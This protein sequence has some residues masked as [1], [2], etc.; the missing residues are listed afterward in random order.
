MFPGNL[1]GRHIRETGLKGATL[2]QVGDGRV[3]AVAHVALDVVR[4]TICK[5]DATEATSADDVVDLSRE[6]LDAVAGEADGRTLAVRLRLVG[7]T[8]AH[9]PL[10]ADR[11]RWEQTL[12]AVANDVSGEGLWLEKV[13]FETAPCLDPAELASRDDAIGQLMSGLR[14]ALSD[15]GAT[16]ALIEEFS[17]LRRKLPHQVSEGTDGIRLDDAAAIREALVDVEHI[18]LPR[19]LSKGSR[20]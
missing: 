1:Q 17:E 18:L 13:C 11:D 15:L 16:Q 4:W 10:E 14:A 2:I 6:R 9:E 7:T 19:L 8:R 12:R 20:S 5:V 3:A